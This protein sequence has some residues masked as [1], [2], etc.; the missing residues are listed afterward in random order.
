M[1]VCGAK[2]PSYRLP[3][4]PPTDLE[5]IRDDGGPL[6]FLGFIPAVGGILVII[7][8]ALPSNPAGARFDR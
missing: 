4:H 6:W 3:V 1:S 5:S 7:F 2:R 8:A